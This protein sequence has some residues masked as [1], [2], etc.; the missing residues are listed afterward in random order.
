M[1]EAAPTLTYEQALEQLDLRLRALEDGNVSLED[2]LRA[3]EEARA[4][5]KVCE[6]RLE[7]ARRRVDVRAE[8]PAATAA[9]AESERLL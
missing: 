6:E 3:V 2:A 8:A 4:L 7:A 1:T 9:E 5:L